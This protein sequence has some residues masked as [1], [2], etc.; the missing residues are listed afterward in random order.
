MSRGPVV[1]SIS[2]L[3]ETL[4]DSSILSIICCL[5]HFA[6]DSFSVQVNSYPFLSSW[7]RIPSNGH[8]IN[9]VFRIPLR[10]KGA[11]SLSHTLPRLVLASFKALWP[12]LCLMG[13]CGFIYHAYFCIVHPF[14]LLHPLPCLELV[15][16]FTYMHMVLGPQVLDWRSDQTRTTRPSVNLHLD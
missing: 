9:L 4:L 3:L 14:F 8:L 16:H 13:P 5:T 10:I 2:S 1:S 7:K 11:F 15:Y 12:P 6:R